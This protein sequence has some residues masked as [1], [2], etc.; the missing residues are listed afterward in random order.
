MPWGV[1]KCF[2]FEKSQYVLLVCL[3]YQI[4][5]LSPFSAHIKTAILPFCLLGLNFFFV[6]AFTIALKPDNAVIMH[7]IH[8][9]DTAVI[10][11]LMIAL[12]SPLYSSLHGH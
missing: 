1:I 5:L 4:P 6:A 10:S 12:S 2:T 3:L 8:L 7:G 11:F 9:S